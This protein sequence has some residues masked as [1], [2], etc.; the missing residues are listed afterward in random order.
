MGAGSTGIYRSALK[1]TRRER[2]LEE[3]KESFKFKASSFKDVSCATIKTS[4]IVIVKNHSGQ[5]PVQ[6]KENIRPAMKQSDWLI[7]VIWVL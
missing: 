5:C 4:S 2:E 3:K 7:L 1:Q 6:Y